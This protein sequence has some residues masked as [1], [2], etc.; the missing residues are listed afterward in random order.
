MM[1]VVAGFVVH[2]YLTVGNPFHAMLSLVEGG[3]GDSLQNVEM[4]F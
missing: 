3:V 1:V 2:V 4:E